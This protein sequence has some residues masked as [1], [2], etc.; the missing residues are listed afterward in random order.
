MTVAPAAAYPSISQV[1]IPRSSLMRVRVARA[2]LDQ[3]KGNGPNV[4]RVTGVGLGYRHRRASFLSC[5]YAMTR[6]F[7]ES[8]PLVASFILLLYSV[9]IHL[10]LKPDT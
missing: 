4:P 5:R 3:R 10:L 1:P 9:A 7:L 2:V 8:T 6:L